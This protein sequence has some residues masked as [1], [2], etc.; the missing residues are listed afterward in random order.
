MCNQYNKAV[1]RLGEALRLTERLWDNAPDIK[2]DLFP[3]HEAIQAWPWIPTCYSLIEQTFKLIWGTRKG[4]ELDEIKKELIK[5]IEKPS[6][7]HDL[8]IL[9]KNLD[10][11]DQESINTAYES[12]QDLHNYIPILNVNEFLEKIGDG[13]TNWRYLLLEGTKGI[14]ITHVGAM[15]EVAKS[16]VSVL[17]DE[18]FTRH[19]FVTVDRRVQRDIENAITQ[20][21]HAFSSSNSVQISEN[22]RVKCLER[23]NYVCGLIR[24]NPNY[25]ISILSRQNPRENNLSSDER[26]ILDGI[27]AVLSKADRKNSIEYLRRGF[28]N[29][30]SRLQAYPKPAQ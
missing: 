21:M 6:Q 1:H 26:N 23:M 7:A 25:M 17:R 27:C 3:V 16:S 9:F 15:L 24:K 28:L 30:P 12:Y 10:P 18:Y 20:D 2:R 5:K 8:N 19:G 22:F 14:P 29:S 4:V 11:G 13:Y